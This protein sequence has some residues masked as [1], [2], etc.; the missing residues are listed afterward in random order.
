MNRR[1]YLATVAAGVAVGASGC[2]TRLGANSALDGL[3]A[4]QAT[5][6]IRAGELSAERYASVLLARCEQ[7]RTLNVFTSLD[8]QAVLAASRLVD[9]A[10]LRGEV[11][12]P[13]AGLPLLVKDSI[14]VAGLQTTG[15]TPGL[16]DNRP[17]KTALALEMLQAAGAV[18]LA[19]TNMGE[20]ALSGTSSESIFGPVR[21]P[22]DPTKFAGGSS[23]G[24]AAGIAL[25]VAPAGLGT[26]VA[27]SGRIPAAFCGIVGFRPGTHSGKPYPDTGVLPLAKSLSTISPMARTVEDVALLDAA[28]RGKSFRGL[29]PLAPAQIR[30]GISRR[31]LWDA[32][33][34]EVARV[35]DAALAKL[36]FA[37]VGMV[38]LDLGD[39]LGK[40]AELQGRMMM[41]GMQGDLQPYL[42]E[43]DSKLRAEDVLAQ[44]QAPGIANLFRIALRMRLPPGTHQAWQAEARAMAQ[45][46]EDLLERA[47]VDALAFPCEPVTAQNIKDTADTTPWVVAGQPITP[48]TL[49]RNTSVAAGLG[50]P[51]ITV[52]SGRSAQG[53]PVGLEIDAPRGHD[54]ELLAI[55]GAVES[56]LGPLTRPI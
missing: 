26:D 53:L 49:V 8:P 14:D 45:R 24:T 35:T 27:G 7:A 12:P 52:P 2:A 47:G 43:G 41:A 40:A 42:D 32:A 4:T 51:A 17:A 9:L 15:A 10:R 23:G 25:G 44:I 30:L 13:L 28:L 39:L 18:V 11:L 46:L 54:A 6:A 20:L 31:F 48:L 21:N 34:P 37:G 33:E 38:E 5:R 1:E 19:K 55:A 36:R 16:R 22:Y 29:V 3:S 50:L 56:V